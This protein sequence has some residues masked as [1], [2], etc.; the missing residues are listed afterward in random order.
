[1]LWID[2]SG[3]WWSPCA[4]LPVFGKG[5]GM[6]PTGRNGFSQWYLDLR[7]TGIDGGIA[8]VAGDR[9]DTAEAVVAVENMVDRVGMA[10]GLHGQQERQQQDFQRREFSVRTGHGKKN[11]GFIRVRPYRRREPASLLAPPET[12]RREP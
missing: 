11:T 4:G 1:M 10:Q 8:A 7:I 3:E 6:V 9:A 2:Q 12:P 5:Y